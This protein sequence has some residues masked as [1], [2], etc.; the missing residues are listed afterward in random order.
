M[1]L[2]LGDSNSSYYHT[3][4]SI[5][6]NRNQIRSFVLPNG[7]Q[8]TNPNAITQALTDAFV[9]RFSSD[10]RVTFDSD[11]DF[12]LLDPIISVADNNFSTSTVLEDEIK[13][14][15]FDS[16]PDKSPVLGQ[17]IHPL[18]GAFV[19]D[20]LIQDN[21]L[22]AHEVFQAFRSKSGP[23]GWIVIKLDMEKAYDRLEWSYIF[24]TLDKLGFSP[25]WIGWIEECISSSSFSVLVNGVPG[26]KFFPSRGI[27][28]GD[29]I[30][31]YLFIL[32]AELLAR[33][34]SSAANSPTKPV[35]VPVGKTGIRVPFL[36][37][38]DD[39]MIFAKANNYSCLVIRQILDKYCSMSGQMVNYHKSAFQCTGNV[40]ANEKRDFANILGMIE[41]NSLGDYLGCPVITSKMT[42]ET[43]TPVLNKTI[44][45]LPKWKANTLSQAGRSVLLQ[46]NLASKSNYQ[47]QSF[48]LPKH[49]LEN[50]DKTYKIFF[51]NKDHLNKSPNLIGWERICK[52]K[53]AGG[54][55]FRTAEVSNHALQMKLLW[56]IIKDDNNLWV[57]LVRKHYIK[58]S[59]LFT[60][61]VSKSASWQW[62][63]L[64]R[65][66]DTFKK[67]L[68]WHLGDG[69]SIRFWSD[70]WVFQYPLSSIIVPTPR[71]E[72]YF[73]D[74]CIL[75]SGRWNTQVLLSLVPP[76]IVAHIV[77]IYIPSEPQLDS[78]IWGLTADGEYSVKTE[79]LLAQG[80]LPA[81]AEK[82]QHCFREAN[83]LADFMAHC[84]HTFQ[85]LHYCTLP[86]DFDLSLCIR[87]DV[88]GW[89]PH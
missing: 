2:T 20:R 53:A 46:S 51:W 76:H 14:D 44:N 87:K 80:I 17:I 68:R 34:L 48:L 74:H 23:N 12:A 66:R 64:L 88:L 52:P 24:T 11:H 79:A 8:I 39:T 31:P 42:K 49:I 28:Q 83:K 41:S 29:P 5:Q 13:N 67:G 55:G 32:C 62:R 18:Q 1:Y 25:I 89:P 22:I 61:K 77:S 4:A 84:G 7:D 40:P 19:P 33:L 3:H 54:S 57:C 30:S 78:L 86:F 72:T 35:G 60:I 71:T 37:F 81:S 27:R 47:M 50:L 63:N 6:K 82:V 69:K 56:R 65:L 26:E 73:V 43:F 36:T 59:N 21:I 45:Q 9:N 75:D 38:A 16:S 10:D 85:D 70:N 15:V 58:N